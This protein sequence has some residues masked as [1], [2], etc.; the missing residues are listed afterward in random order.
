MR[1]SVD[2]NEKSISFYLVCLETNGGRDNNHNHIRNQ[3]YIFSL[4]LLGNMDK[5]NIT[6]GCL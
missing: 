3:L 5:R 6:R 1:S 4:F 2:R